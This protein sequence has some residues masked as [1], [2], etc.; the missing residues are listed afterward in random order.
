MAYP[1]TDA[2][3]T[4]IGYELEHTAQQV[5]DTIDN[6]TERMEIVEAAARR[7]NGFGLELDGADNGVALTYTDPISGTELARENLAT[8]STGQDVALKL[9]LVNAALR[10]YFEGQ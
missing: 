4:I 10:D 1:I 2:S 7:L 9:H 3:G 6:L 8:D 5:D